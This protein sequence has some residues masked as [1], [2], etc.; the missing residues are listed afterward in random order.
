[1]KNIAS[2][3]LLVLAVAICAVVAACGESE[4]LGTNVRKTNIRFWNMMPDAN[5]QALDVVVDNGELTVTGI[6]FKQEET[7]YSQVFSGPRNFK[8]YPVLNG[9]RSSRPTIDT[10]ADFSNRQDQFFTLMVID[11]AKKNAPLLIRDNYNLRPDTL[12][13]R[14]QIR[15]LHLSPN[16]PGVQIGMVRAV[17]GSGGDTTFVRDTLLVRDTLV[18]MR[19]LDAA[20][21]ASQ[22]GFRTFRLSRFTPN[23]ADTT[24]RL[25]V[26]AIGVGDIDLPTPVRIQEKSVYTIVARGIAG[27]T[28]NRALEFRVIK[29]R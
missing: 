6:R 14:C 7:N 15:F 29:D 1:M 22:A 4:P 17:I 21:I 5:A 13:G 8:I 18:F 19:N 27:E 20:G 9:S 23:L 3:T 2:L 11:S 16:A 10:I 24:V 28:G 12:A 26:R 25:F